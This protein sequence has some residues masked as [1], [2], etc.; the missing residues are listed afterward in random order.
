MARLAELVRS[1]A[2]FLLELLPSLPLADMLLAI[3]G[4]PG[5]AWER[6]S[7]EKGGESWS[8]AAGALLCAASTSPATLG[9]S[10]SH[11]LSIDMPLPSRHS[12]MEAC[13]PVLSLLWCHSSAKA[14]QSFW[15]DAVTGGRR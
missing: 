4:L 2:S 5:P 11:N 6:Q 12:K 10:S 1:L 14:S 15:L 9:K 13:C 7:Q 3:P 8:S